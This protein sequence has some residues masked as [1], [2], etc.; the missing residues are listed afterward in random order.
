MHLSTNNVI[1]LMARVLKIPNDATVVGATS[2]SAGARFT[3]TVPTTHTVG[4]VLYPQ[5][6]NG[7][8]SM[9]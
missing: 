9:S 1:T 7:T 2:N 6:V 3:L 4:S 8:V 5:V